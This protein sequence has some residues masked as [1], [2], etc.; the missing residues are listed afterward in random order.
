MIWNKKIIDNILIDFFMINIF[1]Q[2]Q[3]LVFIYINNIILVFSYIIT[4]YCD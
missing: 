1:S 2:R 3:I 4:T